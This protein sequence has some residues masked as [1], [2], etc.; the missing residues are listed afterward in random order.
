MFRKFFLVASTAFAGW[1]LAGGVAAASSIFEETFPTPVAK[2]VPALKTALSDHH[3]KILTQ[4]DILHRV[5][6]KS[7]QLNIKD[8]NRAGYSNVTAVVF[9]NPVF[10]SKLLNADPAAASVCPLSLTV[11]GLKGKTIIAY[12][13]REPMASGTPAQN[14]ARQIDKSVIAA[15]SGLP[16]ATRTTMTK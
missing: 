9:C 15:L 3:F 1:A 4:I 5:A 16:K 13:E 12:P 10:F 8:F 2:V 7:K 14:I 11:Y 6:A